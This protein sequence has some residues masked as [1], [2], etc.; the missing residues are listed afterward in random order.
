VTFAICDTDKTGACRLFLDETGSV[1]TKP[2]GTVDTR[3]KDYKDITNRDDVRPDAVPKTPFSTCG[4]RIVCKKSI[5][6]IDAPGTY[7]RI[8]PPPIV[9]GKV[10]LIQRFEVKNKDNKPVYRL[11]HQMEV[12]LTDDGISAE[13]KISSQQLVP[14]D[15]V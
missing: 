2:D 7:A 11:Q 8:K 5:I 1:I 15:E 14:C 3:G 4:G 6:Y 9:S 10:R 13:S 12:E